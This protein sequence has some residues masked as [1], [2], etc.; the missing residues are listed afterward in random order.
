MASRLS[1]AEA[2]TALLKQ[3]M[4][5][6][7]DNSHTALKKIGLKVLEDLKATQHLNEELQASKQDN[8]GLKRAARY[9]VKRIRELEAH[10]DVV[11]RSFDVPFSLASTPSKGS[12][13]SD[14]MGSSFS[15]QELPKANP[16][17]DSKEDDNASIIRVNQKEITLEMHYHDHSGNLVTY[18]VHS[19]Y[20]GPIANGLPHGPGVLRFENG[21]MYLGEFEKGEMEGVG[22][23]AH[24]QQ[25]CHANQVFFGTFTHNEFQ[26]DIKTVPPLRRVRVQARQ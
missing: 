10:V 4:D 25:Y 5:T 19:K 22:A 8:V 24:R 2:A 9:L 16:N 7:E 12:A 23:F 14:S 15:S 1:A 21:D 26:G 20:T 3:E 11:D 13:R 18:D 17:Q 6:K